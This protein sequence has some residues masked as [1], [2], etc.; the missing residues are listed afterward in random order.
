[1]K[2]LNNYKKSKILLQLRE[3]DIYVKKSFSKRIDSFLINFR[4]FFFGKKL[5][6]FGEFK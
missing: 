1:M 5:E 3:I 6:Y 2:N 4:N